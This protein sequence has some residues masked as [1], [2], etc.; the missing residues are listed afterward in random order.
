MITELELELAI[1]N[2]LERLLPDLYADGYRLESRQALLESNRLDIVLKREETKYLILELKQ[3]VPPVSVIG[4]LNRYLRFWRVSHPDSDVAGMVIGNQLTEMINHEIAKAGFLSRA[5]S[6]Q[7]VLEAL[8]DGCDIGTIESGKDFTK[9]DPTGKIRYLLSDFNKVTLPHGMTLMQPWNHEKVF[10]ALIKKGMCH[11]DLWKKNIYVALYP[12]QKRRNCA[13]LYH[14]DSDLGVAVAPLHFNEKQEGWKGS[15]FAALEPFMTFR[16][17][18]QKDTAFTW[19]SAK[20]TTKDEQQRS[21]NAIASALG[22][23]S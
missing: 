21:W 10:H 16:H 6:E 22:L 8:L 23:D 3:G 12:Q 15:T 5:I 1:C 4:Q 9:S 20:G 11:K 18:D 2:R 17:R 13:I 7:M 14:P 19:Y